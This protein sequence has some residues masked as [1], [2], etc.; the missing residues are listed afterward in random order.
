MNGQALDLRVPVMRIAQ[1]VHQRCAITSDKALRLA[2]IESKM[3]PI[4]P[5]TI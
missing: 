3:Q 4:K 5:A 1:I 2:R